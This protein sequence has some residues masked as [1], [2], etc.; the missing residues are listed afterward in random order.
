MSLK[1]NASRRGI[2]VNLTFEE[3]KKLIENAV[4]FYCGLALA[5]SGGAL[6]RRNNERTYSTE[7]VVPCCGRCNKTFMDAYTYSEKLMLSQTIREIDRLRAF[8]SKKLIS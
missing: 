8:S 2:K 6:D 4:C 3:Y 7:T 5:A 1:A